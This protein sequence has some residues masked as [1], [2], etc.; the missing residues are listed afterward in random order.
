MKTEAARV[1]QVV[2]RTHRDKEP[3]HN[4]GTIQPHG[5][6]LVLELADTLVERI[7]RDEA[8]RGLPREVRWR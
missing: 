8:L 1:G 5:V 6:L 2:D 4:P 7:R 3:I